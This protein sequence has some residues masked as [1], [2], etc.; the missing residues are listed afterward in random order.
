MFTTRSTSRP[1]IGLYNNTAVQSDTAEVAWYVR[2]RTLHRR[3]LLIRP[4]LPVAI[5]SQKGFYAGNDISVR[6]ENGNFLANSLSDLTRRECRFAHPTDKFPFNARC[7]GQ[8]GL[9]TLRECSDPNW[10]AGKWDGY[11]LPTPSTII[12]FWLPGT[13]PAIAED[14]LGFSGKR[15]ADDVILTNVIG[16]DVK[17]WDPGANGGAG[18][19]VDLGYNPGLSASNA[20]YFS[21]LG[22]VRSMLNETAVNPGRV[23]DTWSA[24]YEN[25]GLA[26]LA[27][28]SQY[29]AGGFPGRAANGLDDPGASGASN[30]IVDDEDEKITSP[31]YPYPLRGILVTIRIF[32]PDSRQIR[33]LTIVQDFL[34]K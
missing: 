30:G 8:L 6:V 9:P 18:A 32:E 3:L 22:D 7:W 2:G 29:P 34:P 33:E 20:T 28:P 19:Y 27:Y 23:Y 14:A 31:P 4:D 5:A 25:T 26:G 10:W 24:H 12:D 11:T 17:A 15:L 13:S 21:G 1:F 16:F